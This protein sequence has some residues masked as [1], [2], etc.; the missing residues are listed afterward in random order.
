M[1]TLMPEQIGTAMLIIVGVIATAT[2]V[3]Q[4]WSLLK[5]SPPLHKEYATK[6]EL[7]KVEKRI[8]KV[9][10][11]RQTSVGNLHEKIDGIETKVDRSDAKLEMINTEIR[12]IR[13]QISRRAIT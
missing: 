5:P 8:E 7:E 12:E 10:A 1:D 4:I 6:N 3:L 2:M 9:A 11:E 13:A